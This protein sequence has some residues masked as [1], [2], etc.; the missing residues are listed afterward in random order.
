MGIENFRTDGALPLKVF[1]QDKGSSWQDPS[2]YDDIAFRFHEIV[3]NQ[4]GES[5]S[6]NLILDIEGDHANKGFFTEDKL[7]QFLLALSKKGL[8]PKL[9]F[10]PDAEKATKDWTGSSE[11]DLSAEIDAMTSK[12]SRFNNAISQYNQINKVDL[13]T[14]EQFI[15]YGHDLPRDIDTV[16]LISKSLLAKHPP[17]LNI[18]IWTSGS[19]K[20]G[21]TLA[22]GGYV[23]GNT[24]ADAGNLAEIYN[25][26]NKTVNKVSPPPGV[27]PNPLIGQKT[28]PEE[29]SSLGKQMFNVLQDKDNVYMHHEQLQFPNR[30]PQIFNWS[31][32]SQTAGLGDA[33]VFGG[34]IKGIPD[35]TVTAGWDSD[36]FR[37]MLDS[38]SNEFQNDKRNTNKIAP[39]MGIWTA[40]HA[41]PFLSSNPQTNRNSS[42]G[43]SSTA[44][45]EE[46]DFYGDFLKVDQ[47][48]TPEFDQT[49]GS[50]IF[51]SKNKNG[52]GLVPLLDDFG[53]IVSA[54]NS[55]V[56]IDDANYLGESIRLSKDLGFWI[57]MNSTLLTPVQGKKDS[58]S[59]SIN[60]DTLKG[61]KYAFV[62]DIDTA[63]EGDYSSSLYNANLSGK[64]HFAN[65]LQPGGQDVI[66]FEDSTDGDYNDIII[67][68]NNSSGQGQINSESLFHEDRLTGKNGFSAHISTLWQDKFHMDKNTAYQISQLIL[69]N[70]KNVDM[71]I[72]VQTANPKL[73]RPEGDLSLV[74]F[75]STIKQAT[76]GSWKG[77]IIYHPDAII[78]KKDNQGDFVFDDTD[79][80]EG[81]AG[82]K[83]T[84][85]LTGKTLAAFP[86]GP[87]WADVE[88]SYNASYEA[89]VDWLG[90]LNLQILKF[91]QSASA[92]NKYDLPFF[93][94]FLYETENSM[95]DHRATGTAHNGTGTKYK[96]ETLYNHDSFVRQYSGDPDIWNNKEI[97]SWDD[98]KL[99][100]TTESIAN[101]DSTHG[102][103]GWGADRVHVQAWDFKDGEDYTYTKWNKGDKTL[104]QL[105]PGIYSPQQASDL[106]TEFFANRGFKMP[107]KAP[108]PL[109]QTYNLNQM[110]LPQMTGKTPSTHFD[111]RVNINFT[112]YEHEVDFPTFASSAANVEGQAWIWSA[113]QFSEFITRFRNDLPIRLDDIASDFGASGQFVMTSNDLN[114]GIWHPEQVLG[115]WFGVPSQSQFERLL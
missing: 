43:R 89:Y 86:G 8:R 78:T 100:A 112:F 79:W 16:N 67:N 3:G 87:K 63:I 24:F 90:I 53:S 31:G 73:A 97:P 33:P 20:N 36:S 28:N 115:H 108:S 45:N 44:G 68:F 37:K 60:W 34:E 70:P 109:E 104:N 98:I 17:L 80:T 30:A 59:A 64:S 32:T 81:W 23:P 5:N 10:Y 91:N 47:I 21:V 102:R 9:G 56:A 72:V 48:Y 62:A 103:S 4:A 7:I 54:D 96:D 26:Y 52:I 2:E 74:E 95:F 82:F 111:D 61:Q 46:V 107:K 113:T 88:S 84:H 83:P 77:N 93:T 110:I 14:F 75:L 114:L 40:E 12:M 50:F 66:G 15:S 6:F 71:D 35:P 85:P 55:I 42:L 65:S 13:P 39:V 92:N 1:W 41:L 105:D 69:A 101:W 11:S 19:W 27:K 76:K 57:D 22:D 38:Y 51:N 18:D 58:F 106:F 49:S 25:F 94:E 29:A 99:S